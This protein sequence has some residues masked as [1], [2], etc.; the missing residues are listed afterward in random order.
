M[1]GALFLSLHFFFYLRYVL[2]QVNLMKGVLKR[3]RFEFHFSWSLLLS[4]ASSHVGIETTTVH[5]GRP[6][7]CA[8]VCGTRKYFPSD[9]EA[10]GPWRQTSLT[11]FSYHKSVIN[12]TAYYNDSDNERLKLTSSECRSSPHKNFSQHFVCRI[13]G[14]VSASN[15]NDIYRPKGVFRIRQFCQ[16]WPGCGPKFVLIFNK[17]ARFLAGNY[18]FLFI[19]S[20]VCF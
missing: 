5:I 14:V 11:Y 15:R 13:V 6:P 8:S 1:K 9:D 20:I 2:V 7:R 19:S 16:T 18:Y 3:L 17:A 12:I 4:D 10:Q